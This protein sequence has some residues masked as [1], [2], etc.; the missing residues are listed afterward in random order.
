MFPWLIKSWFHVFWKFSYFE[1][2]NTFIQLC[3]LLHRTTFYRLMCLLAVSLQRRFTVSTVNDT[4]PF[5]GISK[6][7]FLPGIF[8]RGKI[9]CYA[10]FPFGFGPDFKEGQK[11]PGGRLPPLP[12]SP[13][14]VEESQ[15]TKLQV[16]SSGT[17]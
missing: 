7:G 11:S 10:N 15:K 3:S 9:Y 13:L 17:G 2:Q 8:S 14:P 5:K 6:P 16:K 12:P 1:K 4:F